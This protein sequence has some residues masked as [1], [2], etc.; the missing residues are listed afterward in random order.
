MNDEFLARLQELENRVENIETKLI[1]LYRNLGLNYSE[2]IPQIEIPENVKSLILKG[3]V[4]SAIKEF[5][6]TTGASLKDAKTQIEIWKKE[7]NK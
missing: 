4:K 6:E 1:Y 7:L 3:K 2:D 5:K